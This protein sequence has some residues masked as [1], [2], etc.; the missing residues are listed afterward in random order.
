[1]TSEPSS[2]V[3]AHTHILIGDSYKLKRGESRVERMVSFFFI[4]PPDGIIL[5]FVE[6]DVM[7]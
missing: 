2:Q 6:D 3:G 5:G 1:M 7:L 4:I